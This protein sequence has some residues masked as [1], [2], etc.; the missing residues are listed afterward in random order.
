M[1]F[2]L[3]KKI[4]LFTLLSLLASCRAQDNNTKGTS[5][6]TALKKIRDGEFEMP[7][8]AF[9]P[10]DGGPDFNRLIFESSPYLL[11]HA[12]N[13]VDWY[14]WSPEAFQ[15]A[16][17]EDK[18]IFLSIGYSTCHWCHVMEHESF[19]DTT[20]ANY[21][22]DN[23]VS[24]KVDRE[25]RPDIDHI[26]MTVCQA[27]TG[28]G[29]W[30]MTII[31]TPDQKPFF[32]G[33]YFPKESRYGRP[34]FLELL[35][36]IRTAW[37]NER[38]KI[39]SIGE[40]V[41]KG[42]HEWTGTAGGEA[43]TRT[44]L[45]NAVSNLKSTFDERYGGFGSA[46]KFPMGHLLSFLL[47]QYHRSKDTSILHQVVKTLS[48]MYHGGI[49]DHLGF[50]FCR[51]STDEKWF[52]PHFEKMLYDNALLLIAYSEA[53]QITHNPLFEQAAR[54]ICTYVL[55]DMTEKQGG[56]YSAENADSEGEEGK[57]YE[58]THDEIIR[59]LGKDDG[60]FAAAYYGVEQNGNREHGKNILFTAASV[61]ALT[62]TGGLTSHDARERIDR[63][64]EKLFQVRAKRIHPSLDDKVQTSWNGL[65]IAALAVASRAFHDEN[66][67][68]SAMRAADFILRE[69]KKEDGRL[70]HV[71]RQGKKSIEGYLEDYSY[72]VYGLIEVYQSCFDA[73]YLR[74]ATSFHRVMLEDFLDQNNGGL[75]FSSSRGEKLIAR[76]K[77][78]YDGATPSGNSVAAYNCI[79][80]A[81]LTGDVSLETQA[82]SI[83]NAFSKSISQSPT[84]FTFML[85]A[86]DFDLGPSKEIIVAGK[87]DADDTRQ[88]LRE[89]NTSFYPRTIVLLHEEGEKGKEIESIGSF[90]KPYTAKNGK[91]TAYICQNFV[92]R[93]PTSDL[94]QI[95]KQLEK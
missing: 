75:Y 70:L 21:L 48:S 14:P 23:F 65:M 92:C 60:E 25:E 9:L 66:Y 52:A 90:L 51:Y 61:E 88:I 55:R 69:M 63:I 31:M 6:D 87:K 39:F 29:G 71:Y 36:Q 7:D 13:P 53:F 22:N 38:D 91:A 2:S 34:G 57:F 77:E 19:E 46:P 54:E 62:H 10:P 73:K 4:F 74:E 41:Q 8:L 81:R 27:M 93:L 58:W 1:I 94:S 85:I 26:Y 40:Q 3:Q 24:I 43:L 11:Q 56:F 42:L 18:P 47:R 17:H 37:K 76:T 84:G 35:K 95:K 45:M 78:S 28:S 79:R 50:G 89:I 5:M 16:K 59:A 32:A 83:M 15:R 82:R 80:F 72:F 33:T 20:I 49:Y 64:R 44:I 86:F 67:I 12:R 68:S 30:P